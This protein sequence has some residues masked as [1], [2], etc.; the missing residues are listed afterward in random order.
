MWWQTLSRN[1][2]VGVVTNPHPVTENFSF[3][4]LITVQNNHDIWRRVIH[5]L[6]SGDETNL[7][8][9]PVPFRQ[10]FLSDRRVS[11]HYW[12]SKKQ[13]VAQFIIPECYI[14]TVL[15]LV[16][17]VVTDGHPGKRTH[18]QHGPYKMLLACHTHP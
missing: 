18:S 4:D 16:N 7:P 3:G 5:A 14:P 12:P 2:P 15:K 13:V 8:A 10:F 1:V 6:E 9:L 17:N 11:C